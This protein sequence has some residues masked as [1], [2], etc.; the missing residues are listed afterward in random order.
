[1]WFSERAYRTLPPRP[2]DNRVLGNLTLSRQHSSG[3]VD[4]ASDFSVPT[5]CYHLLYAGDRGISLTRNHQLVPV[6]MVC[7]NGSPAL[8]GSYVVDTL[9]RAN[10]ISVDENLVENGLQQTPLAGTTELE[11]GNLLGTSCCPLL[12]VPV[13]SWLHDD[14]N[15]SA[16]NPGAP[17][18]SCTFVPGPVTPHTAG[19][20]PTPACADPFV[21]Y[22]DE[23]PPVGGPDAAQPTSTDL[24]PPPSLFDRLNSD[25]RDGFLQVWLPKH[26]REN[27]IRFPRSGLGPRRHNPLGRHFD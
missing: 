12:R 20:S 1:M 3:T 22:E 7:N 11:L 25:Q 5:G 15:A 13:E 9:Y 6:S 19:L 16:S 27:V 2:S 24:K 4:F 8:A 23:Q 17:D 21:H 26:F 14:D 10:D 18:N